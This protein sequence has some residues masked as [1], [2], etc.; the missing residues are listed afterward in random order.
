MVWGTKET[1]KGCKEGLEKEKKEEK[2]NRMARIKG[3]MKI[4]GIP[5]LKAA[6]MSND[7][8]R[9]IIIESYAQTY[10]KKNGR[11]PKNSYLKEGYKVIL[12]KGGKET[13]LKKFEH[14]RSGYQRKS[15]K[16]L[17]QKALA[18]ARSYMKKH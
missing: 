17:W 15:R 14:I 12:V 6:Y 1:L 7:G 10:R 16:P 13:V 11:Y 2:V 3:W 5:L 8:K 18:F 4:Y 9:K